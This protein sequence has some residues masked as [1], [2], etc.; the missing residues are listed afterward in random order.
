MSK[1]YRADINLD[2]IPFYLYANGEYFY[3]SEYS[4]EWLPSQN[5][6]YWHKKHLKLIASNVKLK[7]RLK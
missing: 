4:G 5:S 7:D 1:L 3:W 2:T 6:D